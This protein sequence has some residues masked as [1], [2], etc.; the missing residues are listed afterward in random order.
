MIV[1]SIASADPLKLGAVLDY[2]H[3]CPLH[4]DIED[5]N[6]TENI[7][8]GMK[9]VRA[10]TKYHQGRADAH[11]FVTEPYKYIDALASCGFWGV[12]FQ[13]E[14]E[15]YPLRTLNRIRDLGMKAGIGL[16]LATPVGIA[17]VFSEALDYVIVMTGEPDSRS[18]D[19]F[20]GALNKIRRLRELL[21]ERVEIWA[22]GGV[23][24]SN[25]DA[26]IANG[27]GHLV[28]GRAAFSPLLTPEEL[29]ELNGHF[30]PVGKFQIKSRC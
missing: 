4:V 2:F 1:P 7:T 21:P 10:V 30:E 22:D 3:G 27:A 26:C 14:A 8:F 19:F 11:L 28:F 17:A 20:P 15:P 18:M 9:T 16:N 6:F 5:G 23:N 12:C 25:M 29:C 24:R 13:V